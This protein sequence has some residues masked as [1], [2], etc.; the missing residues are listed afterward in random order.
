MEDDDCDGKAGYRTGKKPDCYTIDGR[1]LLSNRVMTK[2]R[3]PT[4]KLTR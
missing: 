3:L 1:L 4:G 2:V